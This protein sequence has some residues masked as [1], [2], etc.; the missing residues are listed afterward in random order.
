MDGGTGDDA[1]TGGGDKAPGVI[2]FRIT[3]HQNRFIAKVGG[4]FKTIFNQF[5]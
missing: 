2:V 4:F 5:L 1:V 3:F